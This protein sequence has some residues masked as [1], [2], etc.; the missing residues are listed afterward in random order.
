MWEEKMPGVQF[1]DIVNG[2]DFVASREA[3][4]LG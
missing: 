1:H 4:D 3:Q 2:D